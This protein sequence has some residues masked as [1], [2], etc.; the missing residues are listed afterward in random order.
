MKNHN[1][2]IDQIIKETLTQ[3]E[4]KF[5]DELDEQ[6]VFK[7]ILGVFEGKNGWLLIVMNIVTLVFLG[8]FIYCIVQFFNAEATNELIVW[9]TG[10]L[11]SALF[12]S[13]IKV[14]IWQLMHKNDTL[15]ELKRIELQIAALSGRIKD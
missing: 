3:E 15:R 11:F 13:M 4:A 8:L 10:G 2:E 7:K 14:Y 6:N 5:Y 12:I 1:E 9:A